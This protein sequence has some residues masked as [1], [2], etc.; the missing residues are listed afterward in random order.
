MTKAMLQSRAQQQQVE[1][2][3]QVPML[4][5]EKVIVP[6]VMLH[7]RAQQQQMEREVQVPWFLT[8]FHRRL[9]REIF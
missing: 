9:D 6:K 5:Q 7:T 8:Q 3:V 4:T 2:E 1:Q